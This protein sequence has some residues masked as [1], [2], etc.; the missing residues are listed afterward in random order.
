MTLKV[1]MVAC[2]MGLKERCCAY[3][4]VG[5]EGPECGRET[6]LRPTLEARAQSG[7][8]SA[9]RLP[10]AAYPSCQLTEEEARVKMST[11]M[12]ILALALAV[13]CWLYV[14][15]GDWKWRRIGRPLTTRDYVRKQRRKRRA[16]RRLAR[17]IKAHQ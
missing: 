13:Y 4:L 7:Q 12:K 9:R 16:V 8:M 3:L 11:A 1:D 14:L 2:G 17:A 5:P 10:G 15:F 6:P